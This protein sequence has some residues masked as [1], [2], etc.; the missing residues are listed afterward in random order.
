MKRIFL[1]LLFSPI[2]LIAQV[3][4]IDTGSKLEAM[5]TNSR[6]FNFLFTQNADSTYRLVLK[7]YFARK[8]INELTND[9]YTNSLLPKCEGKVETKL[10]HKLSTLIF[11]NISFKYTQL[12]DYDTTLWWISNGQACFVQ[13]N[14]S[15]INKKIILMSI[16][17][18]SDTKNVSF[19]MSI[20]YD[21]NKFVYLN[22]CEDH[23]H[24]FYQNNVQSIS[25]NIKFNEIIKRKIENNRNNKRD[26]DG[27]KYYYVIS[28]EKRYRNFLHL[29]KNLY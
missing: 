2:I 19:S 29:L 25:S 14:S 16:V 5:K 13:G 4:P 11:D 24:Y 15:I 9:I 17:K 10:T 27:V 6:Y 1:I 23:G 21:T 7:I 18:T 28:T 26:Y 20:E 8:A 3:K 12:F 22:Y